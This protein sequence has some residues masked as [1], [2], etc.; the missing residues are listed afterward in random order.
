[1][2]VS[3]S[4]GASRTDRVDVTPPADTNA[5]AAAPTTSAPSARTTT[6]G[7]R[8]AVAASIGTRTTTPTATTTS[9]V[10]AKLDGGAAVHAD[11]TIT[12]TAAGGPLGVLNQLALTPGTAGAF[13][14]VTDK[15][16]LP[17]I[18]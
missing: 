10:A 8:A 12:G 15:T 4:S 9:P 18:A 7:G 16:L 1:M 2:S 5:G 17:K 13:D 11:G 6:T 14:K 3:G